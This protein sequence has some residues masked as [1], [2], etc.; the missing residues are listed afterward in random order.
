[1]NPRRPIWSQTSEVSEDFGSLGRW[2]TILTVLLTLALTAGQVRADGPNRAGLVVRFDDERVST[3]CVEF[4]EESLTGLEVLARSGLEVGL[5][6]GGRAVC[7]I[8]AVG[9]GGDNCFCR[10]TGKEC[11]YWAYFRLGPDG[12]WRYS[13]V[14]A[15]EAVVRHG[16]VEGWSWGAGEQEPPP[17]ITFAEVCP[18][19]TASPPPAL[20]P[21]PSPPA[22]VGRPATPVP[23][24]EVTATRQPGPRATEQAPPAATSGVPGSYGAFALLVLGLVGVLVVLTRRGRGPGGGG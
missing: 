24:G 9:C 3:V 8:E 19:P 13:Q 4:S 15:G 11:N 23:E 21:S 10:C 20:V 22:E 14:G 17:A 16:D 7:R 1:M 5:G 12:T 2:L 6:F 18:L